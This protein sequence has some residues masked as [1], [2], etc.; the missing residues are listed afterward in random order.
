MLTSRAVE[1]ENI[2]SVF[3]FEDHVIIALHDDIVVAQS[4][5]RMATT[6]K[7]QGFFM[8]LF[9]E[10]VVLNSIVHDISWE[11]HLVVFGGGV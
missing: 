5:K 9:L 7:R 3:V 10:M 11:A 4:V 8:S 6:D 1:I 2:D